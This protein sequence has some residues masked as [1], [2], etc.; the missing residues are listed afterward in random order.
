M[1]DVEY[2]RQSTVVASSTGCE[3][4]FASTSHTKVHR[5]IGTNSGKVLTRSFHGQQEGKL[6]YVLEV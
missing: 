5:G 4:P 2:K 1:S 3:N 6:I